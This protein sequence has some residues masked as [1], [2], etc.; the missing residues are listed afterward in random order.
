MFVHNRQQYL[1]VR[2]AAAA[3][4]APS[5]TADIKQVHTHDG[6]LLTIDRP[7][8]P[9]NMSFKLIE[10]ESADPGNPVGGQQS[11]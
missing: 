3:V 11:H 5:Q 4:A 1:D 7:L 2:R 6:L 10:M 8:S 9:A